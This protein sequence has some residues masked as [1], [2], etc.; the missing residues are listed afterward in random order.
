MGYKK[1]TIHDIARRLG[2]SASTVSRALHDH[3]RISVSMRKS[4]REVADELGYVP[5]IVA[6][7]LR[8]GRR[9]TFGVIVPHI[10]RH[11]FAQVISGIE[12]VANLAGCHVLVAQT[13]ESEER[14]KGLAMSLSSGLVDG[15]LVSVSME[16]HSSGHF[17]TMIDQGIPVVFFDRVPDEIA[18]DKVVVDD[19]FG[20]FQATE[21]LIQTGKKHIFHFAGPLH[22]NVYRDRQQGYLDALHKYKLPSLPGMV[23]HNTITREAGYLAM[24]SILGKKKRPDAILSAGDFSALGAMLL[25]RE[26]KL[27]IPEDIA[28]VGFANEP[29]TELIS[30]GL[31]S[32]DQHPVEMGRQAARLLLDRLEPAGQVQVA[33]KISLRPELLIRNSSTVVRPVSLV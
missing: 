22:L 25:T 21:H 2:I 1:A 31:S 32:V 7:G 33:R 17:K 9:N 16:S 30:P 6:S 29:F 18:A 27:R 26:K 3:P 15:V 19:Y 13:G 14:E 12:E 4:V 5:N 11:F 28:F 23:I 20:A 24:N 8:K 10:D